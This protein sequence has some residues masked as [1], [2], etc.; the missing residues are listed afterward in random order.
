MPYSAL[1]LG[2]EGLRLRSRRIRSDRSHR[3]SS[4]FVMGLLVLAG[5]AGFVGATWLLRWTSVADAAAADQQR[6]L[7]LLTG[8]RGQVDESAM[9]IGLL[10]A[11][12]VQGEISTGQLKASLEDDLARLR[13][14]D[15][16]LSVA[17]P[18]AQ[19]RTSNDEYLSAVRLFEQA[20]TE[21][22]QI[23][24][25]GDAAH[26]A[27]ALPSSLEGVSQL[28]RARSEPSNPVR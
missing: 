20:A 5:L 23:A 1:A 22:M 27:A 7:A 16:Q 18:P 8:V 4:R 28:Q 9:H 12:Y 25:D 17:S 3:L 14:V 11:Q 21:L 19:M 24:D 13:G 10:S 6:Y 2:H 15:E 26:I